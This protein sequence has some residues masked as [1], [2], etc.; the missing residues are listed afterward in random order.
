MSQD[1]PELK[2]QLS[3]IQ[4]VEKGELGIETNLA[5]CSVMVSNTTLAFILILVLL[6]VSKM[7]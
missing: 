2:A 7:A 4:L 5:L 1:V 3:S 6:F